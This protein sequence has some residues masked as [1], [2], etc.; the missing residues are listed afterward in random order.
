MD[1]QVVRPQDPELTKL[2][3]RFVPVRIVNFKN[4]DLN[5]FKFDYDL[6]FAV[7]MMSPDGHTYARFGTQDHTSSAQR[8]SIPGLKNAMQSVLELHAKA[9]ARRTGGAMKPYTLAD[10]P[11]FVQTKQSK[12]ACYHCHYANNARFRQ[13]RLEG[14]FTK[15]ML[16]QYPHPENIGLSLETDRNNRVRSVAAGSPAAE[17]GV[18][19]GDIVRKAGEIL[20]LSSADLQYG[21]NS[22]PDPGAVSLE[23]ERD[24]K[25]LPALS[26]RLPRGWRRSDI[27]WRPSQDGIGP[28][29]GFWGRP[30]SDD[31][32]RRAGV[33]L[34]RLAIQANFM[35]PGAAW[36]RS[37]GDL[38]NGDVI[39]GWNGE[40][41]PSMT[42]RQFHAN[43]RLKFNVGETVRL[44]VVRAG[45]RT[46]LAVPCIE[47][48]SE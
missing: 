17:A 41:L 48:P 1:A 23:L 15:E 35:F 39:V 37:R 28:Q 25:L 16:F 21:L 44:N 7:L 14:K 8:M 12:D 20:V 33:A 40:S 27:S 3:N 9:P 6:T 2:L 29:I 36:A 34:D 38:R 47:T 32:K 42:T 18:R 26:L 11:A 24:G 5:L 10:N 4:V 30:L 46:E 45:Q 19:P 13:L 22:V 43:F 31:E